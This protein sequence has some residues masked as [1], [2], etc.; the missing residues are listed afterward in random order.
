MYYEAKDFTGL[1]W[2]KKLP[3]PMLQRKPNGIVKMTKHM[4]YSE[5]PFLVIYNFTF[6]EFTN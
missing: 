1:P 3:P 5:C 6:K 2:E 4:E